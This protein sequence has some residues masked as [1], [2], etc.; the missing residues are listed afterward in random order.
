MNEALVM[1]RFSPLRYFN[2]EFPGFWLMAVGTAL[3]C[4]TSA[5]HAATLQE[6]LTAYNA[7][8]YD[9]ALESLQPLAEQGNPKAQA[10]IGVMYDYG[11]GVSKDSAKAVEWY[12]K[13]AKQGISIVQQQLG[14]KYFQGDG[15][16]RDYQKAAYWWKQA[17][18]SGLS[19][20]RYRLGYLHSRGLG[21]EKNDSVAADWFRGAAEQGHGLA[22][23]R[24][25]VMYALGQGMAERPDLDMAARWL[26]QAA[27]K[28]VPEAQYNLGVLLEHGQGIAKNLNEAKHWYQFAADQGLAQ[29]RQK[30]AAFENPGQHTAQ[31]E[32]AFAAP[33]TIKRENW[34]AGQD[35]ARYTLQIGAN[36]NEQGLI[37]YL[38]DQKLG[39][40]VAYLRRELDGKLFYT[41]VYGVFDSRKSAHHASL[42]LPAGVRKNKPWVRKF[43]DL[44][45]IAVP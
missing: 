43:S 12:E 11:Q 28:G 22:Q 34:I 27:E 4:I 18:D 1:K 45:A 42:K 37:E 39:P 6:G 16:A 25:G 17:A 36:S 38:A 40:D 26:R 19:E 41:A 44:Q 35:P 5:V 14:Q 8:R 24:L 20:S 21:V 23:Y 15:V 13:A 30:L 3:W 31:T 33:D 9:K 7:K 10:A 32:L 2:L 29:A